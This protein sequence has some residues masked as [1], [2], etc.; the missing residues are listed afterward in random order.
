MAARLLRLRGLVRAAGPRRLSAQA[1]L[2]GPALVRRGWGAGTRALEC[3]VGV[4]VWVRVS[5]HLP[6]GAVAAAHARS[7]GGAD[8]CSTALRRCEA[9]SGGRWR[10]VARPAR[11]PVAAG[12]GQGQGQD[13][14]RLL[15]VRPA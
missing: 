13:E 2:A 5:V 8:L 12:Q 14:R 7:R 3:G 6:R 4:G 11:S 10:R 9:P 1:R 15:G